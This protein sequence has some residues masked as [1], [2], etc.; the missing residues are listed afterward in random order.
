MK[1]EISENEMVGAFKASEWEKFQNRKHTDRLLW[2]MDDILRKIIAFM[3]EKIEWQY[4]DCEPSYQMEWM[5]ML[6][7]KGQWDFLSDGERRCLKYLFLERLHRFVVRTDFDGTVLIVNVKA[8]QEWALSQRRL[9]PAWTAWLAVLWRDRGKEIWVYK[10]FD[11]LELDPR[12]LIR[13]IK[14]R[15][16]AE[17][18]LNMNVYNENCPDEYR[19]TD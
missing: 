16:G 10:D 13:K 5:I 3:P 15:K 8:L 14:D 9:L 1:K 11:W 12:P 19:I 4:G 6:R 17:A 7:P 18:L 2:L